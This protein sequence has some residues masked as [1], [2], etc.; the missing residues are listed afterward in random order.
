MTRHTLLALVL[1]VG[2]RDQQREQR[3]A[4]AAG[5]AAVA[6]AAMEQGQLSRALY[7]AEQAAQYEPL[8][9]SYRDLAQRIS[10]N[11]IALTRPSLT[12]EQYGR[13]AYQ[14]ESLEARDPGSAHIYATVRAI[15]AFA[16][17]DV[18]K[19]ELSAREVTGR[20]PDY[21]GGWLI[22]GDILNATRRPQDALGAFEQAARLEPSNSRAILNLGLLAAQLG[23][24]AKA[25]QYLTVAVSADDSAGARATLANAHLALNQ[26]LQAVP[27]LTRAIEL[28]PR[29]GHYRVS[30]G[31]ALLKLG[32]LDE[33]AQ[34]FR[35]A[36][37]LGTEPGASRGLGAIA[38][39]RKDFTTANQNFARVLAIS[40]DDTTTLFLAAEAQ[41]GV[42]RPAEAAKLYAR[43]AQLAEKLPGEAERVLLAKDRLA[44]L[45]PPSK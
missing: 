19:A 6:Q 44:R 8:E 43:F 22:L 2:C 7:A 40:P 14:A 28:T 35:D 23:D 5:H 30:L 32:H 4:I 15:D 11:Q 25:V 42:A 41:E 12:L 13:A 29:E 26:P 27:H 3:A 39:Q 9:A 34:A 36:A 10:L 20:R 17:G 18:A 1:L 31:D 37:A 33:A 16:R 45:A 24:F 21:L 38:L